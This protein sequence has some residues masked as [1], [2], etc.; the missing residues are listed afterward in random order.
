MEQRRRNYR[1]FDEIYRK[2]GRR[3]RFPVYLGTEFLETPLEDLELSVRSYN[4]LRRSGI[5]NVGD[6]VGSIERRADLLKIRNL[7]EKSADEI[8][9][10]LMEYQFSILSDEGKRRYIVRIAELNRKDTE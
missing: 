5:R 3:F 6:I 8:M 7:G 9:T 4:C 1:E 10:A 2:Y